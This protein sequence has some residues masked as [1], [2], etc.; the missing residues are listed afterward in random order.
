MHY[1][2]KCTSCD[3]IM[4]LTYYVVTIQ[5][6]EDKFKMLT[7]FENQVLMIENKKKRIIL[8]QF[9]CKVG[10]THVYDCFVVLFVFFGRERWLLL[11]YCGM[12]N[13]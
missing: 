1:Q 8:R 3:N 11:A 2:N 6:A 7:L 10:K 5:S 13:I 9:N 4:K 12:E